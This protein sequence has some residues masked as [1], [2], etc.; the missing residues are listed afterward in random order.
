MPTTP[1]ESRPQ[2]RLEARIAPEIHAVLKRAAEIEGRSLS[3]FVIAAARAAAH[4]TIEQSNVIKLSRESAEFV[5]ELLSGNA[6]IAPEMRRA[7]KQHEK[8][9]GSL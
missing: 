2:A 1:R 3:D 5:A 9:I 4:Q 6:Q 8:L 7:A